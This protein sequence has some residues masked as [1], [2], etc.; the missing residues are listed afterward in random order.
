MDTCKLYLH[1]TFGEL[2]LS[3]ASS[4]LTS[5]QGTSG[6]KT[7]GSFSKSYIQFLR[8]QRIAERLDLQ[9]L[10]SMQLAKSKP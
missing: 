4:D 7:D 1:Q 10:G 2:D 5:D 9:I 8:I 3:G 6:A